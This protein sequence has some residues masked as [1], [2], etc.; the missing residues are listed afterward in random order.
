VSVLPRSGRKP[1]RFMLGLAQCSPFLGHWSVIMDNCG[2]A[3]VHREILHDAVSQA[4]RP[5]TPPLIQIRSGGFPRTES[6]I[7]VLCL[8]S[9]ESY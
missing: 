8:V 1:A 7:P 9:N 2:M 6:P 5:T 3:T 4:S